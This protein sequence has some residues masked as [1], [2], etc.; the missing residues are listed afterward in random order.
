MHNLGR[1]LVLFRHGLRRK[2]KQHSLYPSISLFLS[3]SFLLFFLLF[4][5]TGKEER[6]ERR[7]VREHAGVRKGDRL[8]L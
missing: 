4:S 2:E 6:W 8:L 7:I 5:A 1:G 3:F